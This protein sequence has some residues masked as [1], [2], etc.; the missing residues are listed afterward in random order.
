MVKIRKAI[1]PIAGLG[2]RMLPATKAIPKEMLPIVTKPIIQII[3]EEIQQAKIEQIIFVTHSSK[4]SVENHFDES[5]ELEATLEKRV[6]KSLLNEIKSIS[7]IK[8]TIQTIRQGHAKG[9]GHAILCA[10]T[11]INNEPFAVVLPDMVLK[12][13]ST[14]NDLGLMKKE[15]EDTGNS[16]IL[17]GKVKRDKV[18]NYG[19]AEIKNGFIKKIIEK[20]SI[21]KAPSNLYVVGRYIFQK[22]FLNYLSQNKISKSGEFE[23]S[24]SIQNYIDNKNFVSFLEVQSEVYDCG[25]KLGYLKAV[26]DFAM[27]DKSINK[28]FKSHLKKYYEKK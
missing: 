16:Q 15:F 17:L 4:S 21:K 14:K 9:L 22:D 20:P 6:K 7:K 13:F 3:V 28:D 12:N 25:N 23:L 1:V 5:F 27:E 18:S 19:I 11:L 26:V 24:D 2:T 10:K 8:A